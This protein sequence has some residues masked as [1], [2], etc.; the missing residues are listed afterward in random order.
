MNLQNLRKSI[1]QMPFDEALAMVMIVRN[2]RH[3]IKVAPK[4][5]AHK[6]KAAKKQKTK[7]IIL[8]LS[9]E[10]RKRLLKEFLES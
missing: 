7:D 5:T 9:T 10:Q 8:G 2:S 6:S 1:S 4:K 3:T